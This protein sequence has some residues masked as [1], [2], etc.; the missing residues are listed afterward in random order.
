MP[1]SPYSLVLLCKFHMSIMR[2]DSTQNQ[3]LLRKSRGGANAFCKHVCVPVYVT[4][5]ISIQA[6]DVAYFLPVQSH[7]N[8]GS[9]WLLS[10][11]F[12]NGGVTPYLF[13][14]SHRGTWLVFKKVSL[15]S[16]IFNSSNEWIFCSGRKFLQFERGF[17]Y[18]QN[19][20]LLLMFFHFWKK[21]YIQYM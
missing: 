19:K 15:V 4:A 21:S 3:C 8:F 6:C 14:S 10:C 18:F 16:Y 7:C 9:K 5:E 2:D 20:I 1:E 11:T 13:V 17:L 12:S